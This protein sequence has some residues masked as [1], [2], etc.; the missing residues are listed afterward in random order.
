MLTARVVS[1]VVRATSAARA[2]FGRG[3]LR[4]PSELLAL[5]NFFDSAC[6][7]LGRNSVPR[8]FLFLFS[9][10]LFSDLTSTIHKHGEIQEQ[11]LVD[12]RKA[13][14]C[15]GSHHSRC[16]KVQ[17]PSQEDEASRC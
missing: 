7:T 12:R 6:Q 1:L 10:Y 15:H 16:R 2:G 3:F 17:P 8:F 11:E 5:H 9:T 14:T 13:P 4:P